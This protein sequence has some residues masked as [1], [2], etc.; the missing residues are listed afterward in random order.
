MHILRNSK[1]ILPFSLKNC[2]MKVFNLDEKKLSFFIESIS[3][4]DIFFAAN[5]LR[6]R[7]FSVC[8]FLQFHTNDMM[9]RRKFLCFD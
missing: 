3:Y 4:L 1:L 6:L 5:A 7:I 8:I 2:E 9:Q